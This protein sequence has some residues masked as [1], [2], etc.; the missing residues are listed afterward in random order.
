MAAK[1]RAENQKPEHGS[2]RWKLDSAQLLRM[3]AD[4]GSQTTVDQAAIQKIIMKT[5]H[6]ART[7]KKPSRVSQLGSTG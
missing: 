2:K 1:A 3:S 6:N 7:A 4:S 5:F